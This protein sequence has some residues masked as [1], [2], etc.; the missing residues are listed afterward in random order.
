MKKSI[1]SL[2]VLVAS[3]GMMLAKSTSDPVLMTIAGKPVTLSEFEYLYHKNNSQQMAPQSIDSYLDMF[4]TYKQKV[5]D[6]E[7]EGIDKSEAFQNEFDG[8]RRELAAPYLRAQEVED[9]LI[10]AQYERMKED[11]DVSHIMLPNRGQGIDP[12]EQKARLDS[13]RTAILNGADF[14]DLA[15]RF[16][17]D[18]TAPRNGGHMGFVTAGR[19]PNSFEEA[20]YSLPVGGISEV[21]ST[22]FGWHIIKLNGRRPAQGKVLVEHIL[23]LT[24]GLSEEEAAAKKA[25]IDSIATLIANGADFEAIATAESE[26]PGSKRN[27]G[28]LNWFGSGQMVPEFEAASFALKNGEVSKPIKTSYGYHIIKRLD[29]KGIEP[30]DEA[31]PMI[32]TAMSNDERGQMPATRKLEQLKKKFNSRVNTKNLDAVK[33]EIRAAGGIDSALYSQFITRDTPLASTSETEIT[34]SDIMAEIP[35]TQVP[36]AEGYCT[37]IENRVNSA[38]DDA[39]LEQERQRLALENPEYRNLLNEY[40]DGILLFEVAD[41]KVWS[42]AKQDQDGLNRYFETHRDKYRWEAPKYKGFVVFATSDSL[43]HAAKAFLDLQPIENEN[44]ATELRNEFGKDVKIEKVIAA[45]GENAITD[46]LGFGGEMPEPKGK[47]KFYFGYRDRLID[48]PEDAADVRGAV[49]GDYQ[50]QLEEE[51][52]ATLK[53]KYPAKVKKN[54]L[55]KAK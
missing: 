15:R 6:A 39:T 37:L 3:S 36:D 47:W 19:L 44:L 45:K 7:A 9:S 41:R 43:M 24:Q 32:K 8:Y 16:S 5:A 18:R 1:L 17:I 11:V 2:A 42:K 27:G 54:V 33:A 38:L 26:D 31:A 35:V 14:A 30:Y 53:K 12:Q 25:Q 20:A 4:I 28:K 23:K 22:P 55:K 50:T 46:Y 29:W 52:I 48:A 49:T 13:I 21:I 51:W 10:A 34:L 40:R